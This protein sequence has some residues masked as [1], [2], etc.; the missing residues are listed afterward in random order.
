[1]PTCAPH[2]LLQLQDGV[3][4]MTSKKPRP[5]GDFTN[6]QLTNTGKFKEGEMG[7]FANYLPKSIPKNRPV[8]LEHWGESELIY[9]LKEKRE[10]FRSRGDF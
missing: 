5:I 2:F 6:D 9:F 10:V 7:W 1:M 3:R 4:K 8:Q